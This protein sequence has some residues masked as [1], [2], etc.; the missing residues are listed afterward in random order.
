MAFRS[1]EGQGVR[2][3]LKSDFCG[4]AEK[5]RKSLREP[6]CPLWLK[7]FWTKIRN[8][9]RKDTPLCLMKERLQF[10]RQCYTILQMQAVF[11]REPDLKPDQPG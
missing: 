7:N 9:T 1:G 5:P 6:S 11:H 2:F 4:I 3:G 10:H 8:F